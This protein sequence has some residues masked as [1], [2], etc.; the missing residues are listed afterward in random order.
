MLSVDCNMPLMVSS[1]QTITF[2]EFL[3]LKFFISLMASVSQVPLL[4]SIS[5][6]NGLLIEFRHIVAENLC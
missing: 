1:S 5:A 3:D 4:I 2:S 6:S